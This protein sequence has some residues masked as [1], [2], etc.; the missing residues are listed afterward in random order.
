MK[1]GWKGCTKPAKY[2]PIIAM[3][4]HGCLHSAWRIE[5][6]LSRCIHG[7]RTRRKIF[8]SNIDDRAI[9]RLVWHHLR[10]LVEISYRRK[11]IVT[12]SS[13]KTT[14]PVFCQHT[15]GVIHQKTTPQILVTGS[16]AEGMDASAMVTPV[17]R[18]EQKNRRCSTLCYAA[19]ITCTNDVA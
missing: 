17:T 5:T 4:V 9:T 18:P 13:E 1:Y 2:F 15:C 7:W 10:P 8:L 3:Y 12:A 11:K 14:L 16:V 6:C 19:R